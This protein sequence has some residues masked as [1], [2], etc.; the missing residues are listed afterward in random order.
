MSIVFNLP[1]QRK[2]LQP[3]TAV[4]KNGRHGNEITCCAGLMSIYL[5]FIG[6]NTLFGALK[7]T[8]ML[9]SRGS[10]FCSIHEGPIR[11]KYRTLKTG[12]R[13]KPRTGIKPYL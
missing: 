7:T 1:L 4:D 9:Q 2:V 3:V 5:K 8:K 6:E 10:I 12:I 13:Y 11:F